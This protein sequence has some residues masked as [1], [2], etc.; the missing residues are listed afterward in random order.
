MLSNL[1]THTTFCDGKNTA[2]E[3]VLCA[4]EKGFLSIGFS[5][6]GYTPYDTSYCM[7]DEACYIATVSSLK[8]KY[9]D[10][11]QIYLGCEEDALSPVDRQKFDYII[12]SLHYLNIGGKF[13]PI[14]ESY[15][16]F[17][18]CLALLDNDTDKLAN[19][20]FESFCSY[21]KTRKPDIVGH[22]DLI[23]KFKNTEDIFCGTNYPEISKDYTKKVASCDVIFEVNTGA[24]AKGYRKTPYPSEDLLYILKKN[25]AKITLSSDS[26]SA[27]TLDF[28]F[29]EA[30]AMLK[31]IGFDGFYALC[32]NSFKKFLF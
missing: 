19:T 21:I 14:D 7:K 6:H 23:T 22:F 27:D 11:I 31:D 12:G 15:E 26:H 28:Y 10:K 25:N 3:V 29:G 4:I 32:D 18:K 20:Y 9:K 24:I 13:Y 17:K 30:K 8:E 5:S 2:K 16:G 1:H